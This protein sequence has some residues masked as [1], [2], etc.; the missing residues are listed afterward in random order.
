VVVVHVGLDRKPETFD[1][2]T[3]LDSITPAAGL[4]LSLYDVPAPFQDTTVADPIAEPWA[5]CTSDA[6][7]LCVFTIP[8][9]GDGG[10]NEGKT[11]FVLETGKSADA[12]YE[13][14]TIGGY[15]DGAYKWRYAWRIPALEGGQTYVLDYWPTR[16][17]IYQGESHGTTMAVARKNP[18]LST[19]E[20][21]DGLNL[22]VLFDMSGSV[23][24]S[25]E[26]QAKEAMT[27]LVDALK[28]TGTAMSMFTFASSAPALMEKDGDPI[29]MVPDPISLSTDAGAAQ[30]T[31][32]FNDLPNTY[33]GAATNID[34]GLRLVARNALV[35][36][37]DAVLLVTDGTP[38]V[39]FGYDTE[40]GAQR[41]GFEVYLEDAVFSANAIKAMG[42]PVIPVAIMSYENSHYPI[43]A[44]SGPVE[45]SDY[46]L[47]DNWPGLRD[48]LLA[49]QGLLCRPSLL[50]VTKQASASGTVKIG[51]QITYTIT[52]ENTGD[53]DYTAD[54]PAELVDQ[55]S[56]VAD[57]ATVDTASIT[58]TAGSATYDATTQTL[59][60]SGPL[61]R[62]A[63]VTVTYTVTVT[64]GGNL[65]LA[66]VAMAGYAATDDPTCPADG[67]DPTATAC[68]TNPVDPTIPGGGGNGGSD[69]GNGDNGGS[70]NP[71]NGD[72]GG[73]DTP[74]N[75][76][77]GDNGGSG[78][79]GGSDGD[80]G[81]SDN[82]GEGTTTP[83][84]PGTATTT[85]GTS[86]PAPGGD[87]TT[88]AVPPVAEKPAPSTAATQPAP[89]TAATGTKA[90]TAAT[91]AA[92]PASQSTRQAKAT[93]TKTVDNALATSGYPAASLAATGH[94]ALPTSLAAGL[95]LLI[96]GAFLAARRR[97]RRI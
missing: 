82:P 77:N 97:A 71:G 88:A 9:T 80:N 95:F 5:T 31:Q 12:P 61:A 27:S 56:D 44:L 11:F 66:N 53:T 54:Q 19:M 41:L 51:D 60:W 78:G 37:Y 62:G 17:K 7:G 79:N 36:D 8:D 38:S 50:E 73:S 91:K 48:K 76:D 49:A 6:D 20:C 23:S 39:R 75:G 86:T 84:T 85:P 30:V 22:A 10:A 45:D 40:E 13:L 32:W 69:N 90:A 63:K 18:E 34:A 59:S 57:D 47:T 89:S 67:D 21:G 3:T 83:S 25:E 33:A 4:E 93:V 15:N 65:E 24:A 68:T 16:D 96:G 35:Y 46:F 55:L 14:I 1:Q 72:N 43:R 64:Q 87:G 42:V 52:A 28:G 29:P 92:K 70:D 94:T 2:V 81:G 26:V 74:G 58:A